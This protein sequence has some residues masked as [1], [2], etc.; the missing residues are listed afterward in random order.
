VDEYLFWDGI[1]PT[2]AAHA[3]V[4]H[5]AARVLGSAVTG[6]DMTTVVATLAL[7]RDPLVRPG[8][9]RRIS[10]AGEPSRGATAGPSAAEAIRQRVKEGQKVRVTDDQGREWEAA[11]TDFASDN[12]VLLTK[13]RQ[14][15]VMSV[16]RNPPDRPAA[17]HARQRCA[18]RVC[19]GRL[20]GCSRSSQ[21]ANADCEPGAFFSC[22][23][24][25]A[26]A[27]VLIPRDCRRRMGPGRC[28]DRRA[29]PARPDAVPAR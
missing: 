13:D 25:T 20:L 26:A 5:E 3:L 23:D 12:L 24:P 11:S 18:D 8:L 10:R 17:R 29:D 19:S 16:Q 1:H 28:R 6:D 4:A 21:E 27:Y 15:A 9:G 2:S 14:R 7:H 22:G